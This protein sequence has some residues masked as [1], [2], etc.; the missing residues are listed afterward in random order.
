MADGLRRCCGCGQEKPLVS[1]YSKEYRCKPCIKIQRA[2]YYKDHAEKIKERTLA[3]RATHHDKVKQYQHINYVRH[4]E[5]WKNKKSKAR[6]T[7]DREYDRQRQKK[8][9]EK[10]AAANA[11]RHA[12]KLRAMPAW[13]NDFFI[14]E[15]YDLARLRTKMLGFRWEVDHIVPLKAKL[16]CGLH[17]ENNLQVIPALENAKKSNV[18]WPD[19]P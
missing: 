2:A 16:V 9:P 5:R 7:A 13:A 18:H 6:T 8:F 14:S 17:V 3:W 1:F 11:R 15:S 19:M 12:R 4:I 10:Y